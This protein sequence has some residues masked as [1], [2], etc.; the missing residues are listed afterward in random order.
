MIVGKGG[1]GNSSS[2]H[3]SSYWIFGGVGDDLYLLVLLV[4]Q[5]LVMSWADGQRVVESEI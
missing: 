2:A 3:P 5:T 1:K 4:I